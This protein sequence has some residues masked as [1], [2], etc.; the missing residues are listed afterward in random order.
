MKVNPEKK[1]ENQFP[2][3]VTIRQNQNKESSSNLESFIKPYNKNNILKDKKMDF[4]IK[5]NNTLNFSQSLAF[6]RKEQIKTFSVMSPVNS[7]K[8]IK[9][10]SPNI[11]KPYYDENQSNSQQFI[12]LN[13]DNDHD[14]DIKQIKLKK[15][16]TG[17][18]SFNIIYKNNIDKIAKNLNQSP[19]KENK[20][21]NFSVILTDKNYIENKS[22]NYKSFE[23]NKEREPFISLKKKN[24]EKIR[25]IKI[26][27]NEKKNKN[28]INEKSNN[29]YEYFFNNGETKYGNSGLI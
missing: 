17:N 4:S 8:I 13:G 24:I 7:N 10:K 2:K 29:N 18:N 28:N 3:I 14:D 9:S 27:A 23:F 1:L 11:R 25:C 19:K 20:N 6:I 26:E 5:D 15:N 16:Y 22:G 12:V 21:K